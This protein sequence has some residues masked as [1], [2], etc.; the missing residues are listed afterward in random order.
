LSKTRYRIGFTASE[1]LKHKLDQARELLS[2]TIPDGD[3]AAVF[4]R[5]LDAVIGLQEKHRY[6]I[7]AR[8]RPSKDKQSTPRAHGTAAGG[9]GP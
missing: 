8:P 2:H 5:A 3:L 7:G 6:S 4:E 1:E 9:A